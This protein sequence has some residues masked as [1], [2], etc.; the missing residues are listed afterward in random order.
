MIYQANDI[1]VKPLSTDQENMVKRVLG[2]ATM[3][4]WKPDADSLIV[5]E[6]IHGHIVRVT[7]TRCFGDNVKMIE[8]PQRMDVE[9]ALALTH[10][11]EDCRWVEWQQGI[12]Q[13]GVNP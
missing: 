9:N 8:A 2:E 10:M 11:M 6:T 3:A 4:N 5:F 13:F 12:L 1:Y 7:T